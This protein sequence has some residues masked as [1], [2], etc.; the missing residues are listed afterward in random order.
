MKNYYYILTL[1]LVIGL[2]SC[3][4]KCSVGNIEVPEN[5]V[6]S[7]EEKG[8]NYCELLEKSLQKEKSSTIKLSLLDFDNS[9]GY[10][11]GSILV[12]LIRIIGED[13]YIILL[14]KR[15]SIEKKK[16]EAYIEV[17][18]MYHYDDEVKEKSIDKFFPKLN[19]FLKK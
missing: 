11:H 14:G 5:I 16:V 18:L 10:E 13:E 7:S 4:S 6:I 19:A 8:V 17:G 12:D 1:T 2:S 15:T 3:N 9:L